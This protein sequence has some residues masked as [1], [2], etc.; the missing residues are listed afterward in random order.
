MPRMPAE[1]NRALDFEGVE[2]DELKRRRL[3]HS[4][5]RDPRLAV[6]RNAFRARANWHHRS[7]RLHSEGRSFRRLRDRRKPVAFGFLPAA[8]ECRQG[9]DDAESG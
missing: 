1:R 9:K 2:I 3:A 7:R 6:Y 4:Y 8:A 5:S